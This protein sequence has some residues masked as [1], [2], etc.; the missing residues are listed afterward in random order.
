MK[1]KLHT[2]G[3]TKSN[4]DVHDKF[5]NG[6]PEGFDSALMPDRMQGGAGRYVWPANYPT[7]HP[8]NGTATGTL[9]GTFWIDKAAH[10]LYP[11]WSRRI[12][13]KLIRAPPSAIRNP[14][15][16]RASG[17]DEPCQELKT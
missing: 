7:W 10:E 4:Q 9:A 11:E 6:F 5:M 17:G 14:H 13:H 12:H 3:V 1:A 15:V 8:R 2:A 16:R